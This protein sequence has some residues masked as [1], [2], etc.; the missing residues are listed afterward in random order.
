MTRGSIRRHILLFTVPIMLSILLQQLYSTI[1]SI[2]VGNCVSENAL[3]AVGTC[4]PPAAL[5]LAIASGLSTGCSIIVSQLFGAKQMDELK[6]AASTCL[7]LIT[8]LGVVFSVFAILI[9]RP[10]F[11]ILLNVDGEILADAVTYFQIYSIGLLFQFIY[12]IV[13]GILRSIGDS[14]AS[15]YFLLLSSVTNIVLDLL[16]IIVFSFGVAGAAAATVLAQLLSCVICLYYMFHRYEFFRMKRTEFRFDKEMCMLALKLGIPATLQQC[17]ISLGQIVVQ[18]LVNTFDITSGYAAAV[19]LENFIMIPVFGFNAGLSTFTGQNIGAHE[20]DRVKQGR[21][22]THLY[23]LLCCAVLGICS[24]A[25]ASQLISIFGV[26]GL[27]LNAGISYLRFCAPCYLL[28]CFYMVTNAVLQG[29]GDVNFTVFNSMSGLVIRC[30]VAYLL[31]FFTPLSYHAV[32]VSVPI[33]W[34][35]SLILSSVRYRRE[36]WLGKAII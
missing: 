13:A 9:T 30:V 10:L 23:G 7:L 20:I 17:V 33:S 29:A 5:F 18:R 2:I 25:F 36:K 32:W 22:I 26:S 3:A 4:T 11:A 1:D 28:F 14:K 16:F 12:N 34:G 27:S 8:G 24:F 15:L 19:R 6:K 21:K 31:A 35:Y